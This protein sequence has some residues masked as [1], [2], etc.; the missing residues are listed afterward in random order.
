[1]SIFGSAY[2][3][4]QGRNCNSSYMAYPFMPAT[5]DYTV[6]HEKGFNMFRLAVGWQHVQSNLGGELNETTLEYL[7]SMVDRITEDDNTVI[8]D[9]V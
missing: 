7:D 9:I 8:L 3:A 1:M 6:W 5:S 4:F 2:S